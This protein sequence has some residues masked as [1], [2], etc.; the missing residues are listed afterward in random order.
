MYKR[1]RVLDH[2]NIH[3]I[4]TPGGLL[5]GLFSLEVVDVFGDKG[6]T[7]DDADMQQC[8]MEADPCLEA[9]WDWYLKLER[10]TM[11]SHH[12]L[13]SLWKACGALFY[14]PPPF[15]LATPLSK[16]Q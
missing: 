5:G 14:P 3:D 1:L 9:E 15:V 7:Q 13:A 10:G 11:D 12:D 8:A 16:L 4:Q 6:D 2:R